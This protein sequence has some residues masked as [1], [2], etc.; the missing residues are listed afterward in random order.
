MAED[1]RFELQGVR[2]ERER[3][4]AL[5]R[6][7]M[8]RGLGPGV[9]GLQLERGR[10]NSLERGSRV[11]PRVWRFERENSEGLGF[12]DGP[13]QPETDAHTQNTHPQPPLP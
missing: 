8:V 4:Q 7:F 2:F 9:W 1:L 13:Y 6:V 12:G 10:I 11:E 5:E 3:L